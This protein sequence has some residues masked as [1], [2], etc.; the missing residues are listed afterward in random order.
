MRCAG[1]SASRFQAIEK[2]PMR[3]ADGAFMPAA[4]WMNPLGCPVWLS[5][6]SMYRRRWLAGLSE[7][8]VLR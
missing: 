6:G 5:T 3:E 1:L 2:T 4:G 8:R 7:R